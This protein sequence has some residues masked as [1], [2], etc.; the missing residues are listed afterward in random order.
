MLLQ[1]CSLS[2]AVWAAV[3]ETVNV[4]AGPA[5]RTARLGCSA[6]SRERLA[7]DVALRRWRNLH[8]G[9]QPPQRCGAGRHP[10]KVPAPP[11]APRPSG[12]RGA[13]TTRADG[14]KV[15]PPARATRKD[16]SPWVREAA[17]AAKVQAAPAARA[18]VAAKARAEVRVREATRTGLAGPATRVAAVEVTRRHRSRCRRGPIPSRGVGPQFGSATARGTPSPSPPPAHAA[19]RR[20]RGT[21]PS[22]EARDRARGSRRAARS[23]A[24]P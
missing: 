24:C 23:P 20:V 4:L 6:S 15:V 1:R 19:A 18:A 2:S 10:R 17:A 14:I 7:R 22:R 8:R 16:G 9:D 11:R 13:R 21:S 5:V 3:H 12:D